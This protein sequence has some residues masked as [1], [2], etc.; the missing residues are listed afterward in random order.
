VFFV[1]CH[2]GITDEELHPRKAQLLPSEKILLATT[3]RAGNLTVYLEH[4]AAIEGALAHGGRGKR[5]NRDKI[6]EFVLAFD[7]SKH[8]LGVVATEKVCSSEILLEVPDGD[9]TS[10]YY[11]SLF[12]MTL[13]VSRPA[14]VR[15]T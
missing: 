5:L 6:G 7:E 13:E 12:M 1:N 10:L 4:L 9:S 3:D 8:M 2:I 15:S 11:I 14:A